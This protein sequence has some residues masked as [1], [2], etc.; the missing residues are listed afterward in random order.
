MTRS[1]KASWIVMMTCTVRKE[2]IC[3]NCTEEQATNDPWG[4]SIGEREVE[5]PDWSVDSVEPND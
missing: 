4:F 3:D 2:V 1:K 5:Q